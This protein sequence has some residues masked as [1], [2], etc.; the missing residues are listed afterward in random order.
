MG[1]TAAVIESSMGPR[2]EPLT[3]ITTTASLIQS[4]PFMEMLDAMHRLLLQE[5]KYDTGEATPT[6]AEDRQ[7]MLLL[8]PDEWER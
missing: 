6:L 3:I 2:R 1:Q 8:E 4:G 7:M 5:L